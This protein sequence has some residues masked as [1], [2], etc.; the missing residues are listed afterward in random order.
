M[1]FSSRYCSACQLY[2]Y[3][4]KPAAGSMSLTTEVLCNAIWAGIRLSKVV[5]IR[6]RKGLGS[7]NVKNNWP[8]TITVLHKRG[9]TMPLLI[10]PRH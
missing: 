10:S 8:V 6:A 5:G 4:V 9:L 3:I 2:P 7:L 1:L